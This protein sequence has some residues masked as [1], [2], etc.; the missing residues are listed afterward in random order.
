MNRNYQILISQIEKKNN[1]RK[2]QREERE[3]KRNRKIERNIFIERVKEQKK[4]WMTASSLP[5]IW[6]TEKKI[7]KDE[8]NKSTKTKKENKFVPR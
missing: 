2:R 5:F 1:L 6:K 8:R 3:R 4:Y 7:K